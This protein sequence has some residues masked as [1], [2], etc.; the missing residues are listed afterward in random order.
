MKTLPRQQGLTLLMA[1]IMLIVLTMLALTS[2]KLSKPNVQIVSNMQQR[3][4]A[5]AAAQQVVEEVISSTQFSKTPTNSLLVPCDSARNV[6]CVDSNGDGT[7]DI[8]V[9]LTPPPTCVGSKPKKNSDLDVT[10][11][12]EVGC[13]A[14]KDSTG[15]GTEDASTD[16]SMCADSAW[17]VTAVAVDELTK[18]KV[19]IKQGVAMTSPVT[20]L[21]ANCP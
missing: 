6:R 12:E 13:I 19:T 14:P 9:T 15:F 21:A 1:L 18:S 5:I 16:I 3:D 4:E 7:T 2:F 10:K 20:D 17:E 11:T 8:K